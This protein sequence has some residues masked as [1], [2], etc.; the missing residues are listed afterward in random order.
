MKNS[1]TPKC[2][3]LGMIVAMILCFVMGG[4]TLRR[5]ILSR[6]TQPHT[7]KPSPFDGRTYP[8]PPAVLPKRA[9]PPP[10]RAVFSNAPVIRDYVPPVASPGLPTPG[11]M[12]GRFE[13]KTFL[14][15]SAKMCAVS[16]ELRRAVEHPEQVVAYVVKQCMDPMAIYSQPKT[17]ATARDAVTAIARSYLP[18]SYI[19]SGTPQAGG[20]FKLHVEKIVSQPDVCVMKGAILTP[21]GY[22]QLAFEWE[23]TA[24]GKGEMMLT[25]MGT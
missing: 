18:E 11:P 25:Q 16:L 22:R 21:F 10:P 17:R 12:L 4:V 8:P 3:F 15:N 13:G 7:D 23:D 2:I 6:M 1:N 5:D 19:F 20:V 14:P 24:C 9:D